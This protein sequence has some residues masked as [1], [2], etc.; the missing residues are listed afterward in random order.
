M[1]NVNKQ[2]KQAEWTI[3]LQRRGVRC[4]LLG[5]IPVQLLHP[6]HLLPTA[7]RTTKATHLAVNVVFA[8]A[9]CTAREQIVAVGVA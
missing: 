1:H 2:T 3:P 7:Q 9:F 8:F 5:I 6:M 4:F